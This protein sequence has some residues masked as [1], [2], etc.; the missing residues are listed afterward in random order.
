MYVNN[1][2]LLCFIMSTPQCNTYY[3]CNLE[4]GKQL[5]RLSSIQLCNKA[6]RIQFQIGKILQILWEWK[7]KKSVVLLLHRNL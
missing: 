6:W 4:L 7:G 3:W 1:Y 2:L 5:C